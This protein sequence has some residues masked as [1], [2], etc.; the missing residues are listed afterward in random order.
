MNILKQVIYSK[1]FTVYQ[2]FEIKIE[3][4]LDKWWRS[5]FLK[6][7]DMWFDVKLMWFIGMKVRG[8]Q[9]VTKNWLLIFFLA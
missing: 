3:E 2:I 8:V 7:R 9:G 6:M 4:G 5:F 1:Q